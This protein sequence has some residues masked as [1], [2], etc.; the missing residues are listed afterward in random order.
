[1]GLALGVIGC[2]L[3]SVSLISAHHAQSLALAGSQVARHRNLRI[4]E[5]DAQL[6]MFDKRGAEAEG[7]AAAGQRR[8]QP[9]PKVLAQAFPSTAAFSAGNL[10]AAVPRGG[11]GS[12]G[13]GAQQQ[14]QQQAG[15][16]KLPSSAGGDGQPERVAAVKEAMVHAWGGYVQYAFGADELL[17]LSKTGKASY[18]GVATT[19]MDA[20]STLWLMGMK[21]E[22][23]T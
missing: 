5:A 21:E 10:S 12:R 3:A 1:M 6:G 9:L 8:E 23:A 11:S 18:G 20:L 2:L 14:R 16:Q 15:E 13:A 4:V 17:P 22:F 19:I 7:A